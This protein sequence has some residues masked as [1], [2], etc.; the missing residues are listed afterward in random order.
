MVHAWPQ[1]LLSTDKVTGVFEVT[2][3][4]ISSLGTD[5]DE[6]LVATEKYRSVT[7]L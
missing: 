2:L 3:P 4:Q 5:G 7:R 6:T 1:L